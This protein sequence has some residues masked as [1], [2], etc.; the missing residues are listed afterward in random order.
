MLF[1]SPNRPINESLVKTMFDLL[2]DYC[3]VQNVGRSELPRSKSRASRG[4]KLFAKLKFPYTCP[5][6]Y[7]IENFNYPSITVRHPGSKTVSVTRTVTN[8]GPPSTYV[9]NTHGSKGIKV[10]VQPCSL[11]FKRTGEKKFQVILRPIGA[12]HGLPLFG[13]LSWTDGRH[14]LTSPITILPKKSLSI[15]ILM[16]SL[17]SFECVCICCFLGCYVFIFYFY[18]LCKALS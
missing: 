11:T 8:V 9:V 6:S 15:S 3:E 10:L 5:K 12:S 4:S 18:F 7:R 2:G 14:R 13:N 16:L 17:L 1:R